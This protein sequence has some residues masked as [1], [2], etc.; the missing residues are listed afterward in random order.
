MMP[1]M[2][3]P[4]RQLGNT[5][6]QI[7]EIGFGAWAIGSAWGDLVPEQEARDALHA[8]IDA[9]MNF[10]DTADVY[11]AGR[12][13]NLIGEVIRERPEQI[14]VATKMGRTEGWNDSYD[15]I[16][17]TAELACKRLG[18]NT[19]DLVQ[20]HCIPFETIQA[21]K[22]FENLEKIKDAGL[23]RH[24]GVS[25]ETIEEALFCIR[26]SGAATLQV[27]FNIF[28]Q[29]VSRDL[30]NAAVA[31]NIGIIA[32]V[33]LAS[34]VLAGKYPKDHRFHDEDHRH[35][36]A[37]G[38]CFNVGE[39]FAGVEFSKAVEYAQHVE[40]LLADESPDATFAQKS[41]RWILDHPGVSTVIPGAKTVKQARENAAAAAL[42]PL[43]EAAHKKLA[44]YYWNTIDENVRGVY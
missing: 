24:Y 21:G 31:N 42:P 33:P 28:R 13:E 38:E 12:S 18:V 6:L 14:H 34:G 30:L 7:S 17:K 29:R 22:A 5:R 25:V 19:L 11:G 36:N 40:S 20:L 4:K 15:S 2:T 37:N 35:F 8:A 3:I 27:I 44:D 1:T 26:S 43:T 23:I 16:A 41:L 9:G 10:I 39:T 32:R